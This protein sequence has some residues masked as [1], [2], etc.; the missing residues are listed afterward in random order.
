MD[1]EEEVLELPHQA[2]RMSCK[3]RNGVQC[4]PV[5]VAAMVL[6]TLIGS[7]RWV[8]LSNLSK[9]HPILQK[10]IAPI[11]CTAQKVPLHREE[12][13]FLLLHP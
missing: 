6:L 3:W 1:Q 10:P 7:R 9:R 12:T 4:K 2:V 5:V 11:H 8:V 13:Q